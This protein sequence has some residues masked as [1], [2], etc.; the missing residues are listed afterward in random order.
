[1]AHSQHHFHDPPADVSLER[2]IRDKSSKYKDF[3]TRPRAPAPPDEITPIVSTH[4]TPAPTSELEIPTVACVAFW[5]I[6]RLQL[7]FELFDIHVEESI[8][9][10]DVLTF[11][12]KM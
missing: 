1:M 7:L 3:L 4:P 12:Q 11:K 10:P 5:N 9:V 6:Q 8:V 2:I